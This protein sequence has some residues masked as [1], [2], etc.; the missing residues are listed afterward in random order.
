MRRWYRSGPCVVF[1]VVAIVDALAQVFF[2]YVSFFP[3]T[4]RCLLHVKWFFLGSREILPFG[5]KCVAVET[6]GL[7]VFSLSTPHDKRLTRRNGSVTNASTPFTLFFFPLRWKKKGPFGRYER[8]IARRVNSR[9]A[10]IMTKRIFIDFFVVRV[11][12][13]CGA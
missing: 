7:Y 11:A 10:C 6:I 2:S 4:L 12:V 8:T 5:R 9:I 1:V 3:P 13:A